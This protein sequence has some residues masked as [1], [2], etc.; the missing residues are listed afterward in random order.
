MAERDILLQDY[1][2]V[3]R[4]LKGTHRFE[5]HVRESALQRGAYVRLLFVT[6]DLYSCSCPAVSCSSRVCYSRA[7]AASS[8]AGGQNLRK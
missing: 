8:L 6:G 2:Y 7:G 3:C 5:V 1:K 4:E